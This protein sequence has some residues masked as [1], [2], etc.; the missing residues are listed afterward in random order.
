[1]KLYDYQKEGV[2]FLV[3]HKRAYLADEMGLGK[4]VQAIVAARAV[5]ATKVLVVCPASAVL[6][7]HREWATWWRSPRPSLIAIS[8]SKLIRRWRQF[9]LPWR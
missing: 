4:T 3:N 8:Y 9:E 5:Q 1:M 2:Q 7:W 6:N